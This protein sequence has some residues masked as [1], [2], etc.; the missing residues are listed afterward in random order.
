MEKYNVYAR[1]KTSDKWTKAN[2]IT[3]AEVLV[4]IDGMITDS[5][6]VLRIKIFKKR[7]KSK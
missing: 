2:D 6:K 1:E 4:A 5:K 3:R 7:E